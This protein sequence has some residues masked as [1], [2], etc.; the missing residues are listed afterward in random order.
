MSKWRGC[1]YQLP[2]PALAP[3]AAGSGEQVP[4]PVRQGVG[5]R[6]QAA[7][8]THTHQQL[9]RIGGPQDPCVN[10][11]L[12]LN[13]FMGSLRIGMLSALFNVV[14]LA[15]GTIPG[16]QLVLN[17]CLR[18]K[19]EGSTMSLLYQPGV[20]WET[21]MYTGE[22]DR[23]Q[24]A[25]ISVF[26]NWWTFWYLPRREVVL[27]RELRPQAENHRNPG[28]FKDTKNILSQGVQ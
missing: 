23:W 10:L 28:G 4:Y 22:V 14:S 24:G 2:G 3:V 17:I 27:R 20:K 21:D 11:Y 15:S 7:L 6:G 19:E 5:G 16:T 25:A 26:S 12:V 9:G 13:Q 8:C 18:K 1:G